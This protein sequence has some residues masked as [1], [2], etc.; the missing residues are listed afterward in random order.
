[1]S[2]RVCV[3]RLEGVEPTS[4]IKVKIFREEI[5]GQSGNEGCDKERPCVT[6]ELLIG[7]PSSGN[8]DFTLMSYAIRST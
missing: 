2:F 5:G 7:P 4:D 1:M 8:G 3:F 6:S